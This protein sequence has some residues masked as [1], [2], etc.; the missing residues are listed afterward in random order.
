[1]RIANALI[2]DEPV[3]A[4]LNSESFQLDSQVFYD[5]TVQITGAN[6]TNKTF[7]S[8]I[9]ASKVVQDITYQAVD[10]GIAGNSITIA[11]TG[12]ATAGSE[13]VTVVGNA[14]SIQI[15]TAVSTATEVKAAFDLSAPAVA[16]ATATI[17]GTGSNAQVTASVV[18]FVGGTASEV[19]PTA[20]S[21]TIPAHGYL[22]GT[23]LQLTST[24]TLPAG[25]S[26]STDYYVILVDADTIKF[27][28]TQANALAG[29]AVDITGYGTSGAVNTVAIVAA[30]AGSVKL[31]K[32]NEPEPLSPDYVGYSPVWFDIASPAS[33]NFAAATTLNFAAADV[34]YRSLRMVVTTTSGTVNVRARINSKGF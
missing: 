17:T 5:I 8:G 34:G 31:Q 4:G 25:L 23:K 6:P 11:Y 9:K 16:L 21:V 27:A 32:N 18:P 30:L 28:T 15:Q 33:Q 13:V 24:G 7:D 22:T 20:N 26:T 14:I 1:M 19:D 29:T 2:I 10:P 12:G 3:A